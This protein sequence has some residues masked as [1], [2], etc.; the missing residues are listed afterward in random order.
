[1]ERKLVFSIS[2]VAVLMLSFVAAYT[3]TYIHSPFKIPE[4]TEIIG[5]TFN[6]VNI[7]LNTSV[8]LNNKFQ[9]YAG[10]ISKLNSNDFEAQYAGKRFESN[11]NGNNSLTFDQSAGNNS[12]F[13]LEVVLKDYTS[14]V[15]GLCKYDKN[16]ESSSKCVEQHCCGEDNPIKFSV[17]SL[18]SCISSSIAVHPYTACPNS[19]PNSTLIDFYL[20]NTKLRTGCKFEGDEGWYFQGIGSQCQVHIPGN[21]PV[22]TYKLR[23]EYKLGGEGNQ[24]KTYS[25]VIEPNFEVKAICSVSVC[26]HALSAQSTAINLNFFATEYKLDI[27]DQNKYIVPIGAEVNVTNIGAYVGQCSDG[28]VTGGLTPIVLTWTYRG[29]SQVMRGDNGL[30]NGHC[31]LGLGRQNYIGPHSQSKGLRLENKGGTCD[32]SGWPTGNRKW[33]P[34]GTMNTAGDYFVYVDYINAVCD[35]PDYICEDLFNGRNSS[36]T[37]MFGYTNSVSRAD[38]FKPITTY[39]LEVVNPILELVKVPSY[40]EEG[41]EVRQQIAIKNIGV[42]DAKIDNSSIANLKDLNYSFDSINLVTEGSGKEFYATFS[43]AHPKETTRKNIIS[44]YG[45]NYSLASVNYSE[46]NL[47]DYQSYK[48]VGN[49]LVIYYNLSNPLYYDDDY[50]FKTIP[51]KPLTS[52]VVFNFTLS[53]NLKHH[54]IINL[55]DSSYY[56]ITDTY[57]ANT[58]WKN[59]SKAD[60]FDSVNLID[61]NTRLAPGTKVAFEVYDKEDNTDV[62][63]RTKALGNELLGTVDDRGNVYASWAITL[64]DITGILNEQKVFPMGI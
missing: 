57:W 51:P 3:Q 63:I 49:N 47:T 21:F 52:N 24:T 15:G 8:Y 18:E 7:P 43:F 2:L 60:V 37:C 40:F 14:G 31:D 33:A 20:G 30:F 32:I 5:N 22:G 45:I 10:E 17:P 55:N 54:Y 61:T 26:N 16:C 13:N 36:N 50:G 6:T 29:G 12:G 62:G 27:A 38:G 39:K 35:S 1:M 42:G 25:E 53:C 48:L 23:A 11:W 44:S 28:A 4:G 64:G 59:T 41:M 19:V 58:N 9:G 46:I 56:C 34:I